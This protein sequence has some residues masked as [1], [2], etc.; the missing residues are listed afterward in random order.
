MDLTQTKAINEISE[1][2]LPL[3]SVSGSNYEIGR[4]LGSQLKNR[5]FKTLG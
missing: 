1:K 3:Y 2:K 4:L 5:I